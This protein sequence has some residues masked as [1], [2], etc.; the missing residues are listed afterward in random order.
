MINVAQFLQYTF[1]A[2]NLL[3]AAIFILIDEPMHIKRGLGHWEKISHLTDELFSALTFY[4]GY[5]ALVNKSNFLFF[6]YCAFSVLTQVLTYKDEFIHKAESLPKE[7]IIH[8]CMFSLNAAIFT[9]GAVMILLQV[10]PQIFL[11]SLALVGLSIIWQ[12]SYWW[13]IKKDESAISKRY[14]SK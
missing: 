12:I 3:L 1:I 7:H 11:F 6:L 14:I 2:F 8:A 9:L 13:V 4:I 5:L 10:S